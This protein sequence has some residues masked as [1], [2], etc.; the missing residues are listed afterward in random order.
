M[1]TPNAWP[2][3]WLFA[4]RFHAPSDAWDGIAGRRLFARAS[5]ASAT[6]EVGDD[7]TVFAPDKAVMLEGFRARRTCGQGWCRDVD[8]TARILLPIQN[9]GRNSFVIAVRVRGEGPLSLSMDGRSTHAELSPELTDAV[10]RIPA[11]FI[12]AGIHVLSL[13]VSKDGR[14]T[15]DRITLTRDLGA[16]SAR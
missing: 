11:Q 6:I 12:E 3:N 15:V 8:G 10:L 9:A 7:A 1:G 5:S 2:A 14:A 16:E 4:R 13:S